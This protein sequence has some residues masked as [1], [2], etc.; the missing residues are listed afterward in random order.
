MNLWGKVDGWVIKGG[1]FLGGL[2]MGFDGWDGKVHDWKWRNDMRSAFQNGRK[3]TI[4]ETGAGWLDFQVSLKFCN[5]LELV[6]LI[7]NR[8]GSVL[9]SNTAASGYYHSP[10]FPLHLL[11]AALYWVFTNRTRKAYLGA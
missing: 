7:W 1:M 2:R 10:R 11:H 5:N 8:D 6:L 4:Y 3:K 9:A